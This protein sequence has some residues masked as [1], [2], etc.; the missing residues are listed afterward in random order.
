M[1]PSSFTT[2]PFVWRKYLSL[3][4]WLCVLIYDRRHLETP[5]SMIWDPSIG[6]TRIRPRG[7]PQLQPLDLH[8]HKMLSHLLEE[9]AEDGLPLEP[10]HIPRPPNSFILYRQHHH[11]AVTNANPGTPNT[12]IC[13]SSIVHLFIT[14]LTYSARII[15]DMW[16]NETPTVRNSF[17]E[18]AEEKKRLHAKTYPDYQYSPRRPSERVRRNHRVHMNTIPWL[19]QHPLGQQ[20]V[21]NAVND[22]GFIPIDNEFIAAMDAI[23]LLS[24]PNGLAPMRTFDTVNQARDLQQLMTD[25]LG[26]EVAQWKPLQGNEFDEAFP[27]DEMLNLEGA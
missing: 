8:T 17:K 12:Q 27:M 25:Q 9:A 11:H 13:E 4:T 5:I 16:R 2:W 26:M 14:L 24:G 22:D 6:S 15:A 1:D 19:G 20:L 3:P 7:N 23:G 10:A 21:N 18:L